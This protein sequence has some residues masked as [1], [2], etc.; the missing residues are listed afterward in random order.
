[1][2]TVYTQLLN[3]T[4]CASSIKTTRKDRDLFNRILFLKI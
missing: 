4:G 2:F 3:I 1:M